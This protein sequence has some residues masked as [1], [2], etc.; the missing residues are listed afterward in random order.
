MS[1]QGLTLEDMILVVHWR[2]G[3]GTSES[4]SEDTG[5]KRPTFPVDEAMIDGRISQFVILAL[6][7][8]LDCMTAIWKSSK[9]CEKQTIPG[10]TLMITNCISIRSTISVIILEEKTKV[11][12]SLK[13]GLNMWILRS[14]NCSC[15]H[16][17]KPNTQTLFK[18][19]REVAL[20]LCSFV[21][22]LFI[23][24]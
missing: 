12:I 2:R 3:W 21:K 11:R 18:H 13:G 22:P 17:L 20:R 14:Y 8:W 19:L 1:I 9:R 4:Y 6:E 10:A 24:S 16:K 23:L 5:L 7:I 15:Q